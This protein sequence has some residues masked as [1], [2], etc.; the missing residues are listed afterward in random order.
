LRSTTGFPVDA[1]VTMTAEASG[2]GN[3]VAAAARKAD[4]SIAAYRMLT[5]TQMTDN[6]F[7]NSQ[8]QV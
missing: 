7:A 4:S 3:A 1:T 5:V 8:I 6:L 2:A